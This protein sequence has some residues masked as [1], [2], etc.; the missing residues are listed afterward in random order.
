MTLTKALTRVRRLFRQPAEGCVSCRHYSNDP[1]QME[2]ALPGLSAMASAQ[3]SV[4]ASS[5]LCL[6]LDRVINGRRRCAAF[7]PSDG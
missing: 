1:H 4:W 7:E 2:A 6:R 5:G 3:S